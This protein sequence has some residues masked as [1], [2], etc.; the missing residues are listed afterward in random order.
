MAARLE[1]ARCHHN[2]KTTLCEFAAGHK[3]G[4]PYGITRN[5][6][7]SERI[8]GGSSGGS[9]AAIAANLAT[10]ARGE[11]TPAFYPQARSWNDIVSMRPTAGMVSGT[12]MYSDYPT[13]AAF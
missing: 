8:A 12:G 13:E 1:K 3:D 5:R 4:S 10:V 9:G 11:E 7:A 2:R 6:Y